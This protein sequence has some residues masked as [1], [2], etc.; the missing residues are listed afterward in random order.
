MRVESDLEQKTVYYTT[1]LHRGIE[2]ANGND[3]VARSSEFFRV[4]SPEPL[5]QMRDDVGVAKK[6]HALRRCKK[7]AA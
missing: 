4:S 6:S 1:E 3:H 5:R 7:E 2:T